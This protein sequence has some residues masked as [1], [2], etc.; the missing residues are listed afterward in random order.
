[1]FWG[2]PYSSDMNKHNLHCTLIDKTH[3]CPTF[4]NEVLDIL[5]KSK[6]MAFAPQPHVGGVILPAALIGGAHGEQLPS[7]PR[8][9]Q[10]FLPVVQARA[11]RPQREA[12]V[13]DVNKARVLPAAGETSAPLSV[14]PGVR[15]V[16]V[17]GADSHGQH[18]ER[19]EGQRQTGVEQQLPRS[20]ARVA[21]SSEPRQHHNSLESSSTRS[22]IPPG[23]RTERTGVSRYSGICF[24]EL[25]RKYLR[26][27]LTSIRSPSHP[28]PVNE[29]R[30]DE[31]SPRTKPFKRRQ[32]KIL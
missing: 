14:P 9:Q 1:M 12:I 5:I 24:G 20:H 31:S 16:P 18:P 11:A 3:H 13:G 26:L 19:A 4:S 29:T 8:Q 25:N 10:L 30:R 6:P 2:I 7:V 28:I 15:L 27:Y 21:I 22:R 23:A 32:R 17:V